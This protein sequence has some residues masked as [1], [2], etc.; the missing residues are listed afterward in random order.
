MDHMSVLEAAFQKKKKS[1]I[2]IYALLG[3]DN[4]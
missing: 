2:F 4:L 1:V 3:I